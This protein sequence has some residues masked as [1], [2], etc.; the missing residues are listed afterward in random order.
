MR[1][2][3]IMRAAKGHHQEGQWIANGKGPIRKGLEPL[4]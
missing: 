1:F 2:M 4:I 3:H